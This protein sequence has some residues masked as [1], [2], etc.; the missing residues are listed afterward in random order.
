MVDIKDKKDCCGCSACEQVCPKGCIALK[1]DDEGFLYPAVDKFLCINCGLCERVCP[2]INQ[3]SLSRP[4]QTLAARNNDE[5]VRK[6]SSSGG[7]FTAIAENA[8]NRGG[9]VYGAAFDKDWSVKHI[10]VSSVQE[11]SK[12]R[13]SK[14]LQSSLGDIF[15]RVKADLTK[16][17]EVVFSGTP[18]QVA[19]LKR[20]IRKEYVNL[21][22]VD[23]VCHGVP[24]PLVWKKY[25]GSLP[26]VDFKEISFRDKE[27][28]WHHFG[29][30]LNGVFKKGNSPWKQYEK[31]EN[32]LYME[33][34]L[35]NL[36]L[37][38]SCYDC[39]A[40]SGR[41]GSDITLG[42]FWG[43]ENIDPSID[44]DKGL[45]LMLINT[46]K[47]RDLIERLGV[48]CKEQSYDDALRYNPSIEQSVQIPAYRTL[49]MK[50]VRTKGFKTAY[51]IVNSKSIAV[52]IYRRMWLMFNKTK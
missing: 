27:C 26:K 47:G 25:L 14:Y 30:R 31:F 7:V 16:G 20:Y 34:F 21:T 5:T 45:S 50:T 19:G 44:D 32:N 35:S 10:R 51:N 3:G 52:R 22:M 6:E 17:I 33:T 37:R 40:K 48:V 4:L 24:S 23:F 41:S 43:I 29:L 28:G 12:L 18:C 2:V 49:F 9:V 1:A 13:G 39:P 36:T 8:L 46:E 38:P 42:D 11:L 15:S